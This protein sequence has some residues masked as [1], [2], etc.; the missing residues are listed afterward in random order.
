MSR[1]VIKDLSADATLDAAAMREIAGGSAVMRLANGPNAA[2]FA[3]QQ[4]Y[5]QSKL[6]RG[7]VQTR[8]LRGIS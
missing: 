7:L 2:K 3:P 1:I 4:P 5:E 8:N 6:V